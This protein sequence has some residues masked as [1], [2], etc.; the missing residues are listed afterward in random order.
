MGQKKKKQEKA[1]PS[2]SK[3]N[4]VEKLVE[5]KDEIFNPNTLDTEFK[6]KCNVITRMPL[7]Q[8]SVGLFLSILSFACMI[9]GLISSEWIIRTF[10]DYPDLVE[11]FG[12]FKSCVNLSVG[13]KSGCQESEVTE[14]G[15][16]IAFKA[17]FLTMAILSTLA[18]LTIFAVIIRIVKYK[19]YSKTKDLKGTY[20]LA[21]YYEAIYFFMD[22]IGLAFIFVTLFA[23]TL[24]EIIAFDNFEDES[25]DATFHA[26]GIGGVLFFIGLITSPLC[27]FTTAA[28]RNSLK[29]ELTLRIGKDECEELDK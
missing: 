6:A 15:L 3:D 9:A 28:L 25:I 29:K 2:S 8:C 13:K 22:C 16:W 1:T 27:E 5:S 10:P 7:T 17:A 24:D 20:K 23:G 4:D 19:N 21:T 12:I 18:L 26:F 11:S 14:T